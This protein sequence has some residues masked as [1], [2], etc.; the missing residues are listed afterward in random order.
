MLSN[1]RM[2]I[3]FLYIVANLLMITISNNVH[4][5][6]YIF[7]PIDIYMIDEFTQFHIA[8][9]PA[10]LFNP[11]PWSFAVIPHTDMTCKWIVQVC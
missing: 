3:R 6:S 7:V 5:S 4:D 2:L 1:T 11:I 10:P 8:D 9:N